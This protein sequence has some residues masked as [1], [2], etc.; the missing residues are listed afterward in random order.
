MEKN[1]NATRHTNRRRVS[2]ER[3]FNMERIKKI[4]NT[5]SKLHV[6]TQSKNT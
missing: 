1:K 5:Q 2:F 6:N 3:R 4:L